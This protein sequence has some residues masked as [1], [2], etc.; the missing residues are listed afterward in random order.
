MALDNFFRK[1]K[2]EVVT[3][4]LQQNVYIKAGTI[5]NS[6]YT[7]SEIDGTIQK[8]GGNVQVDV[9]LNDSG[10]S[11]E[12]I[13]GVPIVKIYGLSPS[14]PPIGCL[15]IIGF[16]EGNSS[17]AFLL[18]TIPTEITNEYISDNVSP[19]IPPKSLL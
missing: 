3:P 9:V 19:R 11:Q 16:L 1:I 4:A 8:G 6:Y 7:K 12:V 2:N 14:L 13:Y 15:G 18:G 17:T 5:I 10:G